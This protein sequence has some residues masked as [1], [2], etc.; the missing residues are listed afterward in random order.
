MKASWYFLKIYHFHLFITNRKKFE[1]L[2]STYSVIR[3]NVKLHAHTK[4]LGVIIKFDTSFQSLQYSN[5]HFFKY[6]V[7]MS[8]VYKDGKCGL[9]KIDH[10]VH[11]YLKTLCCEMCIIVLLNLFVLTSEPIY[12]TSQIIRINNVVFWIPIF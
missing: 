1:W 9:P 5:Q 4:F 10:H 3:I 6:K 8:I 12:I 11:F 7:L 2:S